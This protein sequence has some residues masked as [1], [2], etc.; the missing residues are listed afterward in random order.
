MNKKLFLGALLLGALTLNS[1]VDDKESASVTN[2]RQAKAEQLKALGEAAKTQADAQAAAAN[3]YAQVQAAQAKLLAAQEAAQLAQTQIEKDKAAAEIQRLQDE[4][5]ANIARTNAEIEKIKAEAEEVNVRNQQQLLQNQKE[6]TTELTSLLSQYSNATTTLVG[7]QRNLVVAQNNLAAWEADLVSWEELRPER[8][9][10]KQ[11]QIADK[12]QEIADNDAQL[13]TLEQYYGNIAAA[14]EQLTK[15]HAES[16]D[17]LNKYSAANADKQKAYT[18]EDAA[19]NKMSQ[20]RY[21]QILSDSIANVSNWDDLDY[22]NAD[23]S[24]EYKRLYLNG[25][26]FSLKFEIYNNTSGYSDL[27]IP[28]YSNKRDSKTISYTYEE[29]QKQYEM[30]YTEYPSTYCVLTEDLYNKAVTTLNKFVKDYQEAGVTKAQ[31]AYD[32]FVAA[33]DKVAT[34]DAALKA[35]QKVVEDAGANATQAQ[36]DA[37]TAKQTAYDTAER[38]YMNAYGWYSEESVQQNKEYYNNNLTYAKELLASA[39][40]VIAK[41][42]SSYKSL[43]EQLSTYQ[44]YVAALNPLEKAAAEAKIAFNKVNNAYSVNQTEIS[45]LNSIVAAG[46]IHV[47]KYNEDGSQDWVNATISEAMDIL[48]GNQTTLNSELEDLQEELTEIENEAY[49]SNDGMTEDEKRLALTQDVED[50]QLT[51]D[52]AQKLVDALKAAIDQLTAQTAE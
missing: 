46:S 44:G 32:D 47:W 11:K 13:A 19:W 31:K 27:Y 52:N 3:A 20:S 17:L 29:G 49:E 43:N 21:R 33:A 2:L 42:K 41:F 35:A 30:S 6:Q 1:C 38:E 18:D 15:A 7:D 8:I 26:F 9:A 24:I 22:S 4:L 34:A 37:V 10:A 40:A 50:A 39:Q 23:G 48:K 45:T 51:V 25:E 14:K 12:T 36:I 16:K 28:L 5:A